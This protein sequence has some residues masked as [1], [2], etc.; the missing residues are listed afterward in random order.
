MTSVLTAG[1]QGTRAA[2]AAAA[3]NATIVA[4]DDVSR[5]VARFVVRPDG[6]MLP[7]TA[8]QYVAVGMRVDGRLIQRPYSSASHPG[9]ADAHELLV[10]HVPGGALTPHLWRA[11]VGTRVRLGPPKGLF[12]LAADD[13]RLHLLI[14]SGTG[15]AP[16]VSM[17]RSLAER[18]PRPRIVLVHGV[19]R[20]E[21]LAYRDTLESWAT[22]G[23]VEYWLGFST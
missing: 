8:G 18:H 7:F 23:L 9:T 19:S 22:A 5:T 16:F 21:D 2:P 11:G 6:P 3:E 17:V 1:P 20:A 15:L 13:S 12:V 14:A 4:R 10:R